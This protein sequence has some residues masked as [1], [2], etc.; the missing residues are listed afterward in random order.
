MRTDAVFFSA[1]ARVLTLG[2]VSLTLAGCVATSPNQPAGQQAAIGDVLRAVG[3]G[4]GNPTISALAGGGAGAGAGARPGQASAL[5]II[6]ML[7]QS[8]ETIDET[9]EVEI[10]RQLS[11]I[12]L[13]S[14]PLHP[15]MRLQAYVNRLG[16]WISLQSPRPNL[17]W[18]FMVLDDPGFNAFAAPGGYVFVTK[19]LVDGANSEAELAGV[20]AHEIVHVVEKHHLKALAKNARAG[21]ATQLVA[22][23]L[24]N[25]LAGNVGAQFLA[26]GKNLYAKGL[27]R[28]DE[29]EADRRGVTLAARAGLDPYGL[30]SLLHTLASVRPDNPQYMLALSTHPP[31]DARLEMLEQ[32][33]GTRLS[34]LA[35]QR[36]VTINQRLTPTAAPARTTTTTPATRPTPRR[37]PAPA[38]KTTP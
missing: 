24:R 36:V 11:S 3:A 14:K 21:L 22:S 5:D 9:R 29:Y 37:A 34:A 15:D 13:G 28:E 25:D 6:E 31:T 2:L 16:R 1:P 8:V 20:L 38:K 23:Q 26:L 18:T 10:G 4:S 7:K 17:P 27:D 30:P 19:G 12:L 35:S 33:M 32:S